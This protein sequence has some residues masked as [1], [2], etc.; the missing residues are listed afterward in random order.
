MV[1]NMD[2]QLVF[3]ERLQ[4][5]FVDLFDDVSLDDAI[6]NLS[7]FKRHLDKKYTDNG[8]IVGKICISQ[9]YDDFDCY[10]NIHREETDEEY[11]IRIQKE[12][13]KAEKKRLKKEQ[14]AARKAEQKRISELKELIELEELRKRVAELE[15]KH[16]V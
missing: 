9:Y 5:D 14:A 8:M 10:I 16:N 12:L 4:F 2:K 6:D 13:E 11:S 3:V 7:D 15:K 1:N